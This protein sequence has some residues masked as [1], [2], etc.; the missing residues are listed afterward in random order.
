MGMGSVCV[1]GVSKIKYLFVYHFQDQYNN[2]M[3]EHNYKRLQ[4]PRDPEL[5]QQKKMDGWTKS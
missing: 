5:D 4:P 1:C 2:E 3:L